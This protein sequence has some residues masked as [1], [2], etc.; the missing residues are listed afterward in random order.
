MTTTMHMTAANNEAAARLAAFTA[1]ARA[2]LK[3]GVADCE[4]EE[5]NTT[6]YKEGLATAKEQE[7][8]NAR[9]LSGFNAVRFQQA[10]D[11]GDIFARHYPHDNMG[12]R[13]AD[14]RD[15][16]PGIIAAWWNQQ[17]MTSKSEKGGNM[18]A[19]RTLISAGSDARRILG[20]VQRRIDHWL[21]VADNA[22]GEGKAETIANASRFTTPATVKHMGRPAVEDAGYGF[23]IPAQ[24]STTRLSQIA[25]IVRLWEQHGDDVLR[26][27][28]LDRML[29]N[30]GKMPADA[31]LKALATKALEALTKVR[32]HTTESP[33]DVMLGFAFNV[34]ARF[35]ETGEAAP[36]TGAPI[37]LPQMVPMTRAEIREAEL[38]ERQEDLAL[39][40][41]DSAKDA[42][43]AEGEGEG[44]AGD[45]E[46]TSAE[47]GAEVNAKRNGRGR[48]G[49]LAA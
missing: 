16:L 47:T 30:G 3:A 19:A 42:S 21:D 23:A 34:L 6:Y 15:A 13:P 39:S 18:A 38:A 48:R 37:P 40:A 20:R 31:S 14:A 41:D 24:K 28:V 4:R 11:L 10:A 35:A 9:R 44:E 5:S 25:E 49:S 7:R 32:E 27:D 12:V 2:Y 26:G 17:K 45:G 46:T 22:E 1:D 43:G 8:N 29:D 33:D 36:A